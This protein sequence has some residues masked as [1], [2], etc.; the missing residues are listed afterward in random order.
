MLIYTKGGRGK[1]S[2][3]RLTSSKN[4]GKS[5]TYFGT[6][7]RVIDREIQHE[8]R[9]TSTDNRHTFQNII[10][11]INKQ[12]KTCNS[13]SETNYPKL[14]LITCFKKVFS[15]SKCYTYMS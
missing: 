10:S 14:K 1:A 2:V 6:A 7:H 8:Q 4:E 12:Y 5:R 15:V 3:A 9:A 13:R 11:K